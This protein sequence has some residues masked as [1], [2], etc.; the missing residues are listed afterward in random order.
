MSLIDKILIFM[1]IASVCVCNCFEWIQKVYER[2]KQIDWIQRAT[3][4]VCEKAINY[5]I[6]FVCHN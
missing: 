6:L 4:M 2:I 1:H 3:Y 5:F